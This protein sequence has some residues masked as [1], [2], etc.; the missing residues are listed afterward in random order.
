MPY[1]IGYAIYDFISGAAITGVLLLLGPLTDGLKKTWQ[2]SKA[3]ISLLSNY[4]PN[5]GLS[6]ILKK[7]KNKDKINDDDKKIIELKTKEAQ[8]WIEKGDY[9]TEE[10][11]K[12]KTE[13]EKLFN[14]II[15]KIYNDIP[16]EAKGMSGMPGDLPE[17]RIE[18]ID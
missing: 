10:Y 6:K 4:D 15:M 11:K 3:V 2:I 1:N 18:D 13:M 17:T 9:D 16:M 8:E 12:Q 7:D 5:T 14:P